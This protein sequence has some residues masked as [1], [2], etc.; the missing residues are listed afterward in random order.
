MTTPNELK[1]KTST[2]LPLNAAQSKIV[3]GKKL[4]TF[5]S[6]K[7][8]QVMLAGKWITEFTSPIGF[9]RRWNIIMFGLIGMIFAS[10]P[11]PASAGEPD[12]CQGNIK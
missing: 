9:L 6:L 5:T 1:T 11:L 3:A 4:T 10:D 7:A 12:K 2:N 8:C